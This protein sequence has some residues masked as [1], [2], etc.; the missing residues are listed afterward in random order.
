MET[1]VLCTG[2]YLKGR[3]ERSGESLGGFSEKGQQIMTIMVKKAFSVRRERLGRRLSRS[4]FRLGGFRQGLAGLDDG[5]E[6]DSNGDCSY[7]YT[8]TCVLGT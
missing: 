3:Q 7:D 1:R 6:G 5:R 2:G 8:E 4:G